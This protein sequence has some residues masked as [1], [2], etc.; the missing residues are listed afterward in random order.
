[1]SVCD[2]VVVSYLDA[3]VVVTVMYVLLFVWHAYMLRERERVCVYEGARLTAMLV[4][5]MEVWLW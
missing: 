2:V 4:L 3:V 5:G 1:M